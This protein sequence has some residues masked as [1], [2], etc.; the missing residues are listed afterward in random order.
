MS[1]IGYSRICMLT[2]T[3]K[4]LGKFSFLFSFRQIIWDNRPCLILFKNG[5]RNAA[6]KSTAKHVYYPFFYH[7]AIQ[8]DKVTI[9]VTNQGL[10]IIMV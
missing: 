8:L 1:N 4:L 3:I 5:G 9:L 2:L 7:W 10:L 6:K